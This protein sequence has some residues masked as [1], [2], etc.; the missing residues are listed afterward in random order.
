ME[1]GRILYKKG[2]QNLREQRFEKEEKTKSGL[3]RLKSNN[4]RNKDS[5]Q[6]NAGP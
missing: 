1:N 6:V 4:D 5:Q 3:Q 2:T